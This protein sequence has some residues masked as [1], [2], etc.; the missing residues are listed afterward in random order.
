[1]HRVI[2]TF[3]L[4]VTAAG[5]IMGRDSNGRAGLEAGAASNPSARSGGR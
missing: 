4:T 3:H 2:P 1:M 5:R